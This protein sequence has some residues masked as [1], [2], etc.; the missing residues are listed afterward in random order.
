MTVLPEPRLSVIT[1][2][3]RD[4]P[5]MVAFYTQVLGFEDRGIRGEI[6]FFNAG[7][8][9]LGLW[10]MARL[11][12]DAGIPAAPAAQGFRGLALAYNARSRG[13]VDEMFGRLEALGVRISRPP[14]EAAWGGYSG[15]F[16]DPE[17][18]PWEIVFNPFWQIDEAGLVFI[19]G[20]K[21]R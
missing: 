8:L 21:E 20:P 18:N 2:G 19:P 16:L 12:S 7:G 17:D 4:F 3:V 15:Y 5:Q 10:D 13:E 11:A 14:H 6:A 1:L 9:V